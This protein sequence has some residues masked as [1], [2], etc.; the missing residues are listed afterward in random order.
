MHVIGEFFLHKVL[1]TLERVKIWSLAD[2]KT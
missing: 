2:T 1:F